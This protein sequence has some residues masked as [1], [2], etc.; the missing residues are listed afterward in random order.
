MEKDTRVPG[1][2]S[3]VAGLGSQVLG[4]QVLVV[5]TQLVIIAYSVKFPYA[6]TCSRASPSVT[7]TSIFCLPR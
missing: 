1:N 3:Q 5:K 6:Y 2:W 4:L 7:L